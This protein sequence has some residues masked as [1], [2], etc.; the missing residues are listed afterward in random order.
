MGTETGMKMQNLEKKSLGITGSTFK[1]IACITMLIDHIG[2]VIVE[3]YLRTLSGN[4]FE[5]VYLF[6]RVLRLIGRLGFPMFCF[7]LVEGVLYTKNKL[8]YAMR[9]LAFCFISE[10]PFNLAVTG[11]IWNK[12]YQNVFFTLFIGFVVVSLIHTWEKK[13]SNWWLRIIGSATTAVIGVGLAEFLKTDY[14]AWGVITI[15][16]MYIL[17]ADKMQRML[18]GCLVLTSYN[19]WEITS[20][21]ALIPVKLYN[22]QKGI[23]LKYVF[24]LFY[25]VHLLVLYGI[26]V[27][28]GLS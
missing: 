14:G 10:I 5:M 8:K 7:L 12:E 23:S 15:V 9:L 22:G 4:E 6:D 16:G 27:W 24:Y 20:F 19:L 21:L 25:P 17:R 18:T 28:M 13:T 1:I 11:D 3:R 26:S 2:A